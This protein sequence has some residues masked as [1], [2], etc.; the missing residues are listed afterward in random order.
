MIYIRVLGLIR[1][2]LD[3]CY[4]CMQSNETHAILFLHVMLIGACGTLF[5]SIRGGVGMA[6]FGGRHVVK[7]PLRI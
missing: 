7:S 5:W 1:L 4:M 6:D 2:P 3:I